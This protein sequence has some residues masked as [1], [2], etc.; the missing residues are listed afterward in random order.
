MFVTVNVAVA[1]KSP[2]VTFKVK[3]ALGLSDSISRVFPVFRTKSKFSVLS[4][5]NACACGRKKKS[6]VVG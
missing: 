2:E 6:L 4:A 1:F 3:S 5:S